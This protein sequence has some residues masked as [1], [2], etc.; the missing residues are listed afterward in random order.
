VK[1][2]FLLIL[3][4]QEVQGT[5]LTPWLTST[6]ELHADSGFLVQRYTRIGTINDNNTAGLYFASLRGVAKENFELEAELFFTHTK[7]RS[8]G[9]SYAAETIRYQF[10]D[11]VLGDSVSAAVGVTF[12]QVTTQ[13]LNDV[14]FIH[15]GKFEGV[16]FLTVGKEL[17]TLWTRWCQRAF[18]VAG[19]GIASRGWPWVQ[20][21][22]YYEW[23]APEGHIAG[24]GATAACG[25]GKHN[26][27]LHHFR[28]YGEVK[29]RELN[30]QGYYS[31]A[32]D[33]GNSLKGL[34]NVRLWAKNC[35]QAVSFS[36]IYQATFSL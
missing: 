22:A 5:D 7:H 28:G 17:S 3:L 25:F 10:L 32:F 15:H 4:C 1:R 30:L 19:M 14:T 36:L 35:P 18:G 24:V 13:S 33:R 11:D 8:P 21:S 34:V 16:F 23:A 26:V 2:W 20:G 12:S 9:F 27:H 31:Y 29:Y 6:Y